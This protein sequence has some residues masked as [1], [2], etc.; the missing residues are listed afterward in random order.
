M[1][2]PTLEDAVPFS[3]PTDG[4][5]WVSND[6]SASAC[7]RGLLSEGWRGHEVFNLTAPEIAWEAGRSGNHAEA[8]H[9]KANVGTLE[10]FQTFMKGRVGPVN[11]EYFKDRPR[12]TPFD[13]TK[14][15]RLLGWDHD[16]AAEMDL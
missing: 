5:A 4:F 13:S 10:L 12:R 15:E 1:V 3:N 7:L 11:E 16:R 9:L 2:K 14:A 8:P 6:A